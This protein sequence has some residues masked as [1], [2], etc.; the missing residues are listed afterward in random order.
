[1]LNLH[2]ENKLFF[3]RPNY[4]WYKLSTNIYS[5]TCGSSLKFVFYFAVKS[6]SNNFLTVGTVTKISVFVKPVKIIE[7]FKH[8]QRQKFIWSEHMK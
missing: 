4:F 2:A 3:Q 1:M 6:N 8:V 5:V 7:I